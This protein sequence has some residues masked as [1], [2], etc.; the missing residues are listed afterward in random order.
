MSKIV[1]L[2]DHRNGQGPKTDD[3]GRV[4]KQNATVQEAHD[5][6]VYH[7]KGVT[8]YYMNQLP[9]FVNQ[10][11]MAALIHH[12]LIAAPIAVV[13]DDDAPQVNA[14]DVLE[15]DSTAPV[16]PVESPETPGRDS[17]DSDGNAPVPR[18]G[19]IGPIVIPDGGFEG[20]RTD[21]PDPNADFQPPEYGPTDAV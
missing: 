13:P 18:I 1:S 8:E 11:I 15:G 16:D 20:V 6:A 10:S 21:M 5:I 19:V 4:L 2:N 14:S 17:G 9:G 12:G 7:A 3:Q